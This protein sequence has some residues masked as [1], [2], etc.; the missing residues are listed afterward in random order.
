VSNHPTRFG[1]AQILI[2][3][4]FAVVMTG[5]MPDET[6]PATKTPRKRKVVRTRKTGSISGLGSSL[7]EFRQARFLGQAQFAG[8][9]GVD[10][11]SVARWEKGT[12]PM[13]VSAILKMVELAQTI[14]EKDDWLQHAGINL[15][16]KQVSK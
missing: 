5:K 10:Q 4:L 14:E 9:L 15:A 12:R 3:A 1:Q 2:A 16:A 8:I 13:P 7:K 6:K 11:P